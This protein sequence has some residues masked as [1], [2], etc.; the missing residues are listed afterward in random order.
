MLLKQVVDA[1]TSLVTCLSGSHSI[2]YSLGPRLT[3]HETNT[4]T[5]WVRKGSYDGA[6][7]LFCVLVLT[8]LIFVGFFFFFFGILG[9]SFS[10]IVHY[11]F[12]FFFVCFS[13]SL[14]AYKS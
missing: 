12:F 7:V 11:A 9:A 10:C 6:W 4:H 13:F 8:I 5:V 14:Y 1:L 3:S 2:F